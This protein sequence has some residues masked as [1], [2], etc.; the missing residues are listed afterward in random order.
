MEN[1]IS[2]KLDLKIDFGVLCSVIISCL[3]KFWRL[4]VYSNLLFLILTVSNYFFQTLLTVLERDDFGS[5][6]LY[7]GDKLV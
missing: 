3:Y 4:Q 2:S 6:S 5:E 7:N 1:L